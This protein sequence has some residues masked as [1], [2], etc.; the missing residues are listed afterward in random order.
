MATIWRIQVNRSLPESNSWI[1]LHESFSSLS[2]QGWICYLSMSWEL[3]RIQCVCFVVLVV[4]RVCGIYASE[5]WCPTD[6]PDSNATLPG[7]GTHY[8][9]NNA[10]WSCF[11]EDHTIEPSRWQFL[12]IRRSRCLANEFDCGGNPFTPECT[13]VGLVR[14]CYQ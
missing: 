7:E 14:V 11:D 8:R 6:G 5:E 12:V 10:L 3:S 1:D 13:G 9:S 2:N 4:C